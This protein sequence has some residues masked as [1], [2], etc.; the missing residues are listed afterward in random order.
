[1]SGRAGRP[2]RRAASLARQRRFA[3]QIRLLV[4]QVYRFRDSAR[5]YRLL[6]VA[7]LRTGDSRAARS[8]LLRATQLAPHDIGVRLALCALH[9]RE[10][11]VDRAL[12]GW[13]EILEAD[14]ANRA[15]RRGLAILRAGTPD[16]LV[17]ISG[18][19]GVEPLLAP[20]PARWWRR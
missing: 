14:P 7:C 9:A 6:G 12:H 5:F 8:F 20:R 15:A 10:G 1:M 17:R 16:E 18:S 19:N 2:L 3:E 11:D 13:L 4:P